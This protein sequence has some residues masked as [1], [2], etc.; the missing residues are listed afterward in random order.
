MNIHE[1]QLCFDP[2]LCLFFLAAAANLMI[3]DL[4]H[5]WGELAL[6]RP[7]SASGAVGKIFGTCLDP[8]FRAESVAERMGF[9]SI[10]AGRLR[11]Q[12]YFNHKRNVQV[13]IESRWN[14][15]TITWSNN[16]L[17]DQVVCIKTKNNWGLRRIIYRWVRLGCEQ[18]Q[19]GW[20]HGTSEFPALLQTRSDLRYK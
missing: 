9:V 4:Q 15:W 13:V 11:Q 8:N 12:K 2:S 6:L 18:Y 19:A 20:G 3:R 14:C 10:N 17:E 16:H 7:K 1:H 5:L